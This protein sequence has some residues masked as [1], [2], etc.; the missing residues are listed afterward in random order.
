VTFALVEGDCLHP[1]T[2]LA[3]LA[4]RSVDHVITDPPY[5]A[6]AHTKGRR[7]KVDG[8]RKAMELGVRDGICVETPLPFVAITD[9]QRVAAAAQMA[10]VARR[11]IL[12]FCQVEA[13]Q[14]WAQALIAGGVQYIRTMI[15]VKPGAQPQ[16]TGDRPG[17]GYESIVVAHR[18]GRKRWNGGGRVGV[19]T[20][21]K[22]GTDGKTAHH[23]TTKPLPLMREL[24]DLFSDPG[25][26]ICDPYAGSG[27]TGVAALMLGRNFLGWEIDAGYATTAIRRLRGDEVRPDP[28]QPSLFGAY[29]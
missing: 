8:W 25:E 19:F 15:W 22:G 4:D 20:F 1:L 13:S 12:V 24:V 21:S 5:E 10:R 9:E 27:S 11:W 18:K 23:P 7:T 17:V 6:D 29:V 26:L 3:C 14:K 28:R 2:G 16:F